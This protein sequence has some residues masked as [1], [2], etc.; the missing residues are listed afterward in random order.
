MRV[1]IVWSSPN[2][3]GLTA[4][5]KN[6][7]IEGLKNQNVEIDEIHINRKKIN[8]CAACGNG[9]GSCRAEGKC[10][11]LDDFAGIYQQLADADGIVFVSAVYYSGMTEQLKAFIDR[12][13]RCDAVHNH[14]LEGKRCILVAC[15]GGTGRGT[16]ECLHDMELALT[17]MNMRA[18]DRIPVVR[19][20]SEYMLTA[21]ESAGEQYANCLQNGFDMY[22]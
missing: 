21:L 11:L 18:Y 13:R 3:D 7:I 12:M 17:H 16:L 14:Y 19:F 2:T 22:Y 5:A 1:A 4:S 8:H 15:A 9:W 10:A 6:S 20:N